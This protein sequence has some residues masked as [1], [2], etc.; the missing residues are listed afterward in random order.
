MIPRPDVLAFFSGY[1]SPILNLTVTCRTAD[2]AARA[3]AAGAPA[4]AVLLH[5]MASASLDIPEMRRRIHQGAVTEVARLTVSYPVIGIGERLNYSTFAHHADFGVFLA[6]YL[7]DR[8]IARAAPTL[9][10][11]DMSHRDYLFATALPWL[12]FTQIRHPVH[13]HAD[14]SIP[15]LAAGRFRPSEGGLT[16]PLAVQV[17]HGLADALHVARFVDRVAER[18]ADWRPE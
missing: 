15:M 2:F 4:F 7:A 12:D 10:L 3:K 8:D 17:H 16:F 9:R 5:A 18:L 1:Q 14:V 6:R 11:D 13:D